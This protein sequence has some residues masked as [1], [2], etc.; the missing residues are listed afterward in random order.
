MSQRS[1]FKFQ[2]DLVTLGG[3]GGDTGKSW[4]THREER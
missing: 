4:K 1:Y 3:V 2:T